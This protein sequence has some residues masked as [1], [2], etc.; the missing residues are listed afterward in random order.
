MGQTRARRGEPRMERQVF[1]RTDVYVTSK[2]Y[3]ST[4][5]SSR[6]LL[7]F[8]MRPPSRILSKCPLLFLRV[9][10]FP[11]TCFLGREYYAPYPRRP[12]AQVVYFRYQ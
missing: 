4:L 2:P 11:C 6:S 1:R 3:G 9:C 8:I 12:T 5:L 10:F 7:R